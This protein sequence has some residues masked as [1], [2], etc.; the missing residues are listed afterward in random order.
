[1]NILFRKFIFLFI[2]LY[3]HFVLAQYSTPDLGKDFVDSVLLNHHPVIDEV[4]SNPGKYHFQ[5]IWTRVL[6]K[7][8]GVEL[9]QYSIN[10]DNEYFYPASLIKFPVALVALE[11]LTTLKKMGISMLDSI[12]LTSCSCNNAT[13][14]YVKKSTNPNLLQFLREMIIMSNNDA[15]NLFFDLTGRDLVNTKMKELQLNEIL[16]KNRFSAGCREQGNKITGGIGFHKVADLSDLVLPCDTSV[17]NWELDSTL[18]VLAGQ[19]HLSNGKILSGPKNYSYTNYVSLKQ[20]NELLINL[21]LSYE[22]REVPYFNI[23]REY[24]DFLIR[25]MGDF[26]RE[27]LN[28]QSV[29]TKIPDYYYKFFINPKDMPTGDGKLRVFNKVGLAS[30]FISDISYFYDSI[31]NVRFFLS[32]AVM[33]KKDGIMDNGK[34]NYDD[35]AYPLLRNIGSLIYKY[36]LQDKKQRA[37]L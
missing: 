21:F 29:L 18:P 13:I 17:I 15:Y 11:K 25:A 12:F 33:A 7:N 32:A 27:L 26:P 3:P 20:A 24:R 5:L 35:L 23:D 31:N 34:N 10:Q 16:L 1:M 19:F 6:E 2:V 28:S 36:E 9:K 22:G 4:L 30:G 8:G 37:N 14:S